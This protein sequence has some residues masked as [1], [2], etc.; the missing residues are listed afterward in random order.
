MNFIAFSHHWSR[1]ARN[2]G[3][4]ERGAVHLSTTA[5]LLC[6]FWVQHQVLSQ[7]VGL[8][9]RLPL[10]A[11]SRSAETGACQ[12]P[13]SYSLKLTMF[14]VLCGIWGWMRSLLGSGSLWKRGQRSVAHL[15]SALWSESWSSPKFSV[16]SA[17][18]HTRCCGVLPRT[19]C[20]CK[21][22]AS[23]DC[24]TVSKRWLCKLDVA[25][26]KWMNIPWCMRQLD[27]RKQATECRFFGKTWMETMMKVTQTLAKI[28][29]KPKASPQPQG[30]TCSCKYCPGYAEQKE[31]PRGAS[32]LPPAV[33]AGEAHARQTARSR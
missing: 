19:F 24:H 13:L 9:C 14:F 6:D 2:V 16:F 31:K 21:V 15:L 11:V 32:L 17:L 1:M 18:L 10:C 28:I 20:V 26:E 8:G 12:A 25:R 5:G 3:L 27:K 4:A 7:A 29:Y 22:L 30:P 23:R 33:L